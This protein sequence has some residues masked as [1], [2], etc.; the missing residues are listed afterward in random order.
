MPNASALGVMLHCYAI[1]IIC[2]VIN[3]TF[4]FRQTAETDGC[5]QTALLKRLCRARGM[6]EMSCIN[7]VAATAPTLRSGGSAL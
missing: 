1:F 6:E 4:E 2:L 5:T 3:A 7:P